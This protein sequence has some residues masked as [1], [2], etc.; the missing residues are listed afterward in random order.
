M[1]RIA[2]VAGLVLAGCSSALQPAGEANTARFERQ[3]GQGTALDLVT[4]SARVIRQQQ[5]EVYRQQTEPPIY[6]E[7]RWRDR[8][9]FDDEQMLG[10]TRAQ[11]RLILRGNQY[12]STP[13]G[14][15]YRL[16]L[17]IE[18]RLQLG[19]IDEWSDRHLTREYREWADRLTEEFRRELEVGVRRH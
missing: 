19:T 5:F 9:P 15:L 17:A 4:N 11:T 10:A 14:P 18:N 6:I 16:Q 8:R 2:L 13:L 1:R 7:T 3:V 12:G